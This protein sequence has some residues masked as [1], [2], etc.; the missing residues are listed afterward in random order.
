MSLCSLN[1]RQS[2]RKATTS[3][4]YFSALLECQSPSPPI[5]AKKHHSSTTIIVNPNKRKS[6]LVGSL[7][8]T[9]LFFGYACYGLQ[10]D[11]YV[12]GRF[13]LHYFHGAA[14]RVIAFY[15][16][17]L[18]V[19][20]GL[21]ELLGDDY[22][23]EDHPILNIVGQCLIYLIYFLWGI[24]LLVNICTPKEKPVYHPGDPIEIPK[25]SDL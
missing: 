21:N 9:A 12:P 6:T 22:A 5:L 11:L 18:A 2:N 24:G 7:L 15:L 25:S 23:R 13:F 20:W 16:F 8:L 14:A 3:K 19:L 17:S 10:H 1:R 4:I